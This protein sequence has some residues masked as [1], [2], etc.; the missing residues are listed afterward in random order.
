MQ[1]CINATMQPEQRDSRD[2]IVAFVHSCIPAFR[3]S[4]SKRLPEADEPRRRTLARLRVNLESPVDPNGTD[5]RLVTQAKADGTSELGE[6]DVYHVGEDV[7]GV[8]KGHDAQ[9]ATHGDAQLGIENG[10]G[11]A[12]NGKAGTADRLRR[13]ERIE[14]EAAD[15]RVAAGKKPLRLR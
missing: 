8:E 6:I 9:A 11:V 2:R 12:A 10:F 13:A 15:G 5:W 7:P 1:E 14:C 3:V 4:P